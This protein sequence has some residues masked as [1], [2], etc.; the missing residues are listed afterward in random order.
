[1]RRGSSA[2]S[3]SAWV[4]SSFA[5]RTMLSP[6]C[7]K[8]SARLFGVPAVICMPTDAPRVKVAATRGYGAEIVTYNRQTEDREAIGRRLAEERGLSL[9]PPYDHPHVIAGAGT[10]ALELV[11]QVEN[12]DVIATPVGG[13]G[14]LSGSCLAA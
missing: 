4:R 14:M 3:F 1:M 13:G 11:S 9:I 12:V 10:A 7:R 8:L 2:S 5:A 6:A